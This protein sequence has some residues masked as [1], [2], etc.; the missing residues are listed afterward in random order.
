M[1]RVMFKLGSQ[2]LRPEEFHK[3]MTAK[4]KER[5]L[6]CVANDDGYFEKDIVDRDDD[7]DEK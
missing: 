2:D 3:T 1:L 4:W 7:D 5:I 6:V